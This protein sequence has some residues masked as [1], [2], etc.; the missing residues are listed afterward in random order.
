M[1]TLGALAP[2]Y[3]DEDTS[4]AGSAASAEA[5]ADAG[6]GPNENAADAAFEATGETDDDSSE[7]TTGSSSEHSAETSG[8]HPG[9]H[10]GGPPENRTT[11][12][13]HSLGNASTQGTV[14]SPQPE[15]NADQNDGG[16]NAYD[17]EDGP[18]GPYCATTRHGSENG[19][20][21]GEAVGRP[22]A[23]SVGRADN[24][25][26]PGQEP[27]PEDGNRG[28]ECDW[29]G[30]RPNQGIA[31]GNPAHTGCVT[32]EKPPVKVTPPEQ[33]VTPPEQPVTPPEQPVTPPEQPVIQPVQQPEQPAAQPVQEEIAGVQQEVAPSGVLPAAGADDHEVLLLTGAGLVVV[34][35]LLLSRRRPVRVGAHVRRD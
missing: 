13:D 16:A 31:E 7:S 26:P 30:S 29:P 15:S 19:L 9:D 28:Y 2:V 11:G 18:E 4:G 34:G 6:G 8:D 21:D 33:P 1:T 20:G 27:G 22:A 35:G 24:K 5:S 14:P 17:C 32:E 10:P 25:N 23:G 3:A 12:P